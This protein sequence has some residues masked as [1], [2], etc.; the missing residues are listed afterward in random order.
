MFMVNKK[1]HEKLVFSAGF[2]S[3]VGAAGA[4]TVGLYPSFRINEANK[5][6]EGRVY[7]LVLYVFGLKKNS[8]IVRRLHFSHYSLAFKASSQNPGG[9]GRR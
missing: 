4:A 7:F 3:V 9:K 5:V 2:F 6:S 8:A 1:P